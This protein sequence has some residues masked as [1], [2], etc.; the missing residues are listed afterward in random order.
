LLSQAYE[1]ATNLITCF[2][3]IEITVNFLVQTDKLVQLIESP[4]FTSLRLQLLEP[5]KYPHL[6][7]ALYGI[8]MLLPQSGAFA[9]LRNRLNSISSLAMIG[10]LSNPAQRKRTGIS[11]NPSVNFKWSEFLSHYKIVQRRHE[12]AKRVG[13]VF[14]ISWFG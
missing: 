5:E 6:Y 10:G 9:T 3:D 2:G 4:V 11:E 14:L 8:L 12:R 7:K 13:I 1:H